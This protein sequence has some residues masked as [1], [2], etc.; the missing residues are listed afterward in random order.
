MA[1]AT[2]ASGPKGGSGEYTVRDSDVSAA[3]AVL[4]LSGS[5]EG[6]VLFV[7]IKFSSSVTKN[8]NITLN[9]G[10][11]AGWDALLQT[12]VLSGAT[13]AIWFPDGPLYLVDGDVLDVVSDAGGAAITCALEIYTS[14]GR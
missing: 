3:N 6:R 7:T 9:S 4:T 13:E 12:V 1:R 2:A 10:E 8:V 11:G 5:Q 14:I